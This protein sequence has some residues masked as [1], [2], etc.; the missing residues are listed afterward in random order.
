MRKGRDIMWTQQIINT[1]RGTFELFTKEMA[2]RFVLH[3]TIHNL[4][5]LGITLRMF[6]C[7]ASCISH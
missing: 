2:N 7:Y 5:K 1:K 3:I 4:M 6:Y